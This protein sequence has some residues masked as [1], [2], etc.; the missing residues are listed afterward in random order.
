[1]L[2]LV[3]KQMGGRHAVE[4]KEDVRVDRANRYADELKIEIARFDGPQTT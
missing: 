1:M 4:I 3:E 2:Q